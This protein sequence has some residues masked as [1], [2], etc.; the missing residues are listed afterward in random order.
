MRRYPRLW[1]TFLT[2][3]FV[4]VD[5]LQDLE[6]I[7]DRGMATALVY[8]D[9]DYICNWFGGQAV[10]LALEHKTASQFRASNYTSFLVDG[11]EYGQVR[12]YGNFSFLR[13][14]EAGHET[15]YY[16]P[17]AMLAHFTR[18][19]NGQIIADGSGL[20]TADY[21]TT[22]TPNSTHVEPFPPLPATNSSS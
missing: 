2:G 17:K 22:G 12:Q 10:S 13:L 14:Y 19:I 16:Q 11:G 18:L 7:I 21:Q 3:D 9:A 8:G 4:F 6:E 15:P 1:L 5:F 20:V